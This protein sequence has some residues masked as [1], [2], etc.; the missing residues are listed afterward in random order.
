MSRMTFEVLYSKH[1]RQRMVLR[2]I[3]AS[4]VESAIQFGSKTR[5]DGQVVATYHY[6]SVVYVVRNRRYFVLTVKPRW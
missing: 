1:A 3:T 6:F 4:E 5:Q 2:G